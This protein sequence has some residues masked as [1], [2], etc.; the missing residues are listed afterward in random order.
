VTPDRSSTH[1]ERG[2]TVGGGGNCAVDTGVSKQSN[3]GRKETM[4]S[5]SKVVVGHSMN[6]ILLDRAMATLHRLS[7]ITAFLSAAVGLQF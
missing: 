4:V 2:G 7:K 3:V 5:S 1:H 6:I